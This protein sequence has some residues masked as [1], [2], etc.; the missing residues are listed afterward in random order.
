[1]VHHC[2]YK[3]KDFFLSDGWIVLHFI[4]IYKIFI[5]YF[6]IHSFIYVLLGFFNISVIENNV[7]LNVEVHISFQYF[8]IFFA[9]TH[10]SGI[11][12][13]Y[14]N[15]IFNF[16]RNFYFIFH[17][18]WNSLYF[19]QVFNGFLISS[20]LLTLVIIACLLDN[21]H[22]TFVKWHLTMILIYITLMINEVEDNFM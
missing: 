11:M 16:S 17:S 10:R 9:F 22:L 4:F 3:E 6:L 14:C 5:K 8:F 2:G 1:M 13:S 12:G 19:Y 7:A 15:S 18:G 21:S 20:F